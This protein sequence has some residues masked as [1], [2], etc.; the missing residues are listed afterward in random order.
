MLAIDVYIIRLYSPPQSCN[1]RWT[2][3]PRSQRRFHPPLIE[4]HQSGLHAD[5]APC[6]WVASSFAA[7]VVQFH[8]QWCSVGHKSPRM[9]RR[10]SR[11]SRPRGDDPRRWRE[12]ARSAGHL[13]TGRAGYSFRSASDRFVF[14]VRAVDANDLARLSDTPGSWSP[15]S[16]RAAL[17]I[18]CHHK[19][20]VRY[21]SCAWRIWAAR[22]T[23]FRCLN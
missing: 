8:R 20:G 5:C 13:F 19:P 7:P 11:R 4:L 14:R 22:P 18:E 9:F 1:P 6:A 17:G 21:K 23:S 2:F 16:A 15:R 12:A 10:Q 3:Q